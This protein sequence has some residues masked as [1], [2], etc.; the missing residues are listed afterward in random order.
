[1][2]Q[3]IP[4]TGPFHIYLFDRLPIWECL[5]ENINIGGLRVS[6][7]S[8]IENVEQEVIRV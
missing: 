4:V 7:I 6:Y 8:E 5:F 1:M 3:C 2:A